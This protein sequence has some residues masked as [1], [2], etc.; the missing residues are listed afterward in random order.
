M[1]EIKVKNERRVGTYTFGVMLILIGISIVLMTFT[2]INLLKYILMFWPIILILLGAEILYLN[3]KSDI[4]VKIDFISIILMCIIVFFTGIF[5]I[6][7]YFVNKVMYDT[8]FKSVLI[9][10]YLNKSYCNTMNIKVVINA[11]NKD[12]VSVNFIKD[13]YYTEKSYARV[14]FTYNIKEENNIT[15]YINFSNNLYEDIFSFDESK[16]NIMDLPDFVENVEITIRSNSIENIS[17][18]GNIIEKNN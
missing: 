4:R 14:N 2:S 8:D 18:D 11:D 7:N 3:S 10:G 17:Y 12:K 13:D 6:G 5:S 15:K 1:E 9:N 16:I